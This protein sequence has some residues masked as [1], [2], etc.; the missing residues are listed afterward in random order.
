MNDAW[1]PNMLRPMSVL[2]GA[3]NC[4]SSHMPWS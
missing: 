4:D 1:S 3:L 2:N